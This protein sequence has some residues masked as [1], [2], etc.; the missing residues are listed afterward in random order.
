MDRFLSSAVQRVLLQFNW[1]S[2]GVLQAAIDD[3]QDSRDE[4][5]GARS[6]RD[7]KVANYQVTI[8]LGLR[9]ESKT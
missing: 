6:L 1:S 9:Y 2:H 7:N 5:R 8:K 4:H 3:R